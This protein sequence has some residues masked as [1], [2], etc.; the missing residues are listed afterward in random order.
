MELLKIYVPGVLKFRIEK[1]K[2]I[3]MDPSYDPVFIMTRQ[4]PEGYEEEYKD[5]QGQYLVQFASSPK[6]AH[7]MSVS[8]SQLS[9]CKGAIFSYQIQAK[10]YLSI[11][12]K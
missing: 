7:S 9:I 11:S 12:N 5:I 8:F 4:A 1:D 10:Y 2:L 3:I 6:E